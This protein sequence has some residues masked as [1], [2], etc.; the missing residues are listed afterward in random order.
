MS[1][2]LSRLISTV[3]EHYT[4]KRICDFVQVNRR[5]HCEPLLAPL[6]AQRFEACANLF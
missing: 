2:G 3:V 4:S 1:A 6:C 5:W